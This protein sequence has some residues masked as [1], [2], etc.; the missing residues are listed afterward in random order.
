MPSTKPAPAPAHRPRTHTDPS[1]KERLKKF[2][3]TDSEWAEFLE[4]LP[5]D[6]RAAFILLLEKLRTGK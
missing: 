1:Q 4:Y 5:G 6:S 2:R 3:A